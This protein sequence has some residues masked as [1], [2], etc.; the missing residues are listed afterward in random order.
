MILFILELTQQ[1]L[2]A[3]RA[4]EGNVSGQTFHWLRR[5]DVRV[6]YA[7]HCEKVVDSSGLLLQREAVLCCLHSFDI[8]S[9]PMCFSCLMLKLEFFCFF[10]FYQQVFE[11]EQENYFY[12]TRTGY[13]NFGRSFPVFEN[14]Q[15]SVSLLAFP[16][17][18]SILFTLGPWAIRN[19][20]IFKWA[21]IRENALET[22]SS[23]T[24]RLCWKVH[25]VL[26]LTFQQL[27]VVATSLDM[28][29]S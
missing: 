7:K 13:L 23:A 4:S 29:E 19:S 20:R 17:N 5:K 1:S 27:L 21:A 14:T 3:K 9:V 16:V 10:F 6:T 18:C 8:I 25:A 24:Q 26:V 22:S 2:K 15:H 11:G 28:E 12:S